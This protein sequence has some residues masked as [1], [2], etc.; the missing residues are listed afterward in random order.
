M[1]EE[2]Q[3]KLKNVDR[4]LTQGELISATPQ[5]P[6]LVYIRIF[7]S[8]ASALLK[9]LEGTKLGLSARQ[10]LHFYQS[11]VCLEYKKTKNSLHGII[12]LVRL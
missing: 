7:E 10:T 9:F 4:N 1:S 3:F 12:S 5:I 11:C 2:S 6:S 8:R